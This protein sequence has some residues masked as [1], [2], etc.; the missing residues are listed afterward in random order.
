MPAP[1]ALAPACTPV[2][3]GASPRLLPCLILSCHCA[4][5]APCAGAAADAEPARPLLELLHTLLG[6][7]RPGR[8]VAAAGWHPCVALSQ[9]GVSAQQRRCNSTL[10]ALPFDGSHA[11]ALDKT[12][13]VPPPLPAA[14]LEAAGLLE[15]ALREY[16]ELEAAYLEVLRVG[17]HASSCLGI[18]PE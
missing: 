13:R 2:L 18:L 6:K 3:Q 17:K 10:N 14:M 7:G 15:D 9:A 12:L 16:S 4:V 11:G 8:W 1:S 5:L